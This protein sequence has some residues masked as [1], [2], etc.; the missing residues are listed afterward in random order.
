MG[1]FRSYSCPMTCKNNHTPAFRT[2]AKL[3]GWSSLKCLAVTTEARAPVFGRICISE[4][5]NPLRKFWHIQVGR[6]SHSRPWCI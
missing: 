1:Q 3:S 5:T 2:E 4:L 6:R